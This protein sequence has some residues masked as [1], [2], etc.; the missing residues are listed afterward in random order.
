MILFYPTCLLFMIVVKLLIFN[1]RF[2]NFILV[3]TE[4]ELQLF[5]GYL[6]VISSFLIHGVC[7]NFSI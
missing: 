6:F 7:I 1:T 4:P 5:R 2:L 3:V